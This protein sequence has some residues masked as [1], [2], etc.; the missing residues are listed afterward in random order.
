MVI[1]LDDLI[2]INSNF[3]DTDAINRIKKD[4][5]KAFKK[6]DNGILSL[7]S[8]DFGKKILYHPENISAF[9]SGERPF[10]ITLEIDLT[11]RCNHRC[12]FCFYAEHIGVES[13]KP[14]LQTD[15]LKKRLEEAKILGTK[16]VSFSGG[17]EPMIHKDFDE[18]IIFCKKIGFDVGTITNGSP[19]T[20]RNVETLVTNLQWIR[21]SMAGG[22]RESYKKVQGVDQFDLILK[23]L[24]LLSSKKFEMNS[25]LNIGVRMLVTSENLN[26][27]ENFVNLIKDFHLDYFQI[28]PDQFSDD[29]GL[30]WNDVK[31]QQIF[32]NL[33]NILN[34]TNTKL[35]T[36]AY[37]SAQEDLDY[38]QTCYAHFFKA[39]IVAE[40]FFSFCQN[41]RGNENFY[42]GNIY[43]NSLKEIWL[44]EK[45]KEIE[46]WVR[47]N[48]CGLFCKHMSMNNTLEDITNPNTD[49]T[50]NFVG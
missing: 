33:K 26:S 3:E 18:I 15:I 44:G 8:F 48:N 25:S 29:N 14:S 7:H 43:E 23:N 30:F 16:G 22:D 5:G 40:G 27:L 24:Q 39:A 6:S 13:D 38:P 35:L 41:A 1:L 31:T 36:T 50:P 10:P 17:G 4:T 21:I 47:P 11:N 45:I 42:V 34:T 19:I 9:K 46:K 49:I 20:L 32:K 28:A 37:M 12:S 2:K